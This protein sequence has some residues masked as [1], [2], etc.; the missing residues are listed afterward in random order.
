LLAVRAS[1]REAYSEQPDLP[2]RAKIYF[3]DR[4]PMLGALTKW[5]QVEDEYHA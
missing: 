2:A 5:A 3:Q 4:D 1:C